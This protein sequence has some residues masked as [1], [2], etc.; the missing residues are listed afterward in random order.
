MI[1]ETNGLAKS[2][3]RR[4]GRTRRQVDAVAGVDLAVKE[5]EIFGL[6]GPNGAGKTTTMRMLA[7]VVV[8][9]A[10]RATVAGHD[11]ATEPDAV[12]RRIGY[13]TQSGGL[14]HGMTPRSEIEMQARFHRFGRARARER[15]DRVLDLLDLTGFADRPV[16][17]LSGG[18]RRRVEI[19]LGIVHDP[20]VLFLDEP[21]TGLD[22]QSRAHLWDEVRRLRDGGTTVFLTTHY[23]DE[24]DALCDRLVF[25]EG[26]RV[27][28]TGSP[29]E[30]KRT[31]GGEVVVVSLPEPDEHAVAVVTAQP[32]VER[33]DVVPAGLRLVVRDGAAAVPPLVRAFDEELVRVGGVSVHRPGLDD[34]FLVQTGRSLREA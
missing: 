4:V 32:F 25:V 15:T 16:R 21:T 31:I 6:L 12:R 26:G 33:V 28:A 5:G 18:Q 1:I 2:F 20:A 8:P 10:G 27:V 19:A 3:T 34:V 17:T 24:A 14:Y 29:E 13:V 7:T 22:P 9:D 11:L 23:L 30:L